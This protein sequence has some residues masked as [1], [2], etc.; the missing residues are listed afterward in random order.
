MAK[1]KRARMKLTVSKM[2]VKR[3]KTTRRYANQPADIGEFRITMSQSGL[4]NTGASPI[5]VLR[6]SNVGSRSQY[7]SPRQSYVRRAMSQTF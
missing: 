7:E 5:L 2:R 4:T 1:S 6:E 3:M